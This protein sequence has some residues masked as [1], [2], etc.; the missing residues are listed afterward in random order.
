M[1]G[2]ELTPEEIQ[3]LQDLGGTFPKQDEKHN[4]FTF[5]NKVLKQ[6]DNIKTG[7]LTDEE[8]GFVRM[9]VRTNRE[10]ALYCEKM[11]MKGFANY[12]ESESQITLASSLSKEGFLD[13]LAITQAKKSDIRTTPRRTTNKG[14]FRKKG[15]P[16]QEVV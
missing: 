9:P 2:I 10:I 12:F 14:W 7:N 1:D 3:A 11:G 8:L 4:V 16:M 13:K 6:K 5:F 15:E